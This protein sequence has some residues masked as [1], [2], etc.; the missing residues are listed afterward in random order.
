MVILAALVIVFAVSF[1]RE[2]IE[3]N[4]AHNL[5]NPVPP[6]PAVLATAKTYYDSKCASCHG[7]SGDGK[8]DKAQGLWKTPTNF[9]NAA[10]MNRHTDGDLYWVTTKG[11]WPMPAFENKLTAIERWQLVDYIRTF[12][13]KSAK[14]SP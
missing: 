14:P 11:S 4:A 7:S 5:R 6:T 13:A 2:R 3:E 9:R 12:A 10:Q 1:I 8:G